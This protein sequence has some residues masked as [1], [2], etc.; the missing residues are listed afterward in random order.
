MDFTVG[1]FDRFSV[2]ERWFNISSTIIVQGAEDADY[3]NHTC[4]VC[5]DRGGPEESCNDATLNI[6]LLGAAPRLNAATDNGNI[7]DYA[8][9][10]HI[11]FLDMTG[12][13]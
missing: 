12:S 8:V 4:S 6:F 11:F 13:V 1:P 9:T 10:D 3:G 2:D 5:T 7:V